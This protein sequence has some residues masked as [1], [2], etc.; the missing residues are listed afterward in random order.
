MYAWLLQNFKEEQKSF[1]SERQFLYAQRK[2]ALGVFKGE[3]WRMPRKNIQGVCRELEKKFRFFFQ[4][5][6]VSNSQSLIRK[7]YQ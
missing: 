1:E 4:V 7:I 5:L 6:R 2:K 3:I